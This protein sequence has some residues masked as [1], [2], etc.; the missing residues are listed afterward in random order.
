ELVV[1]LLVMKA[2]RFF[3]AVY[4]TVE[5]SFKV[6]NMNLRRYSLIH[7]VAL[8]QAL[9]FV[10][11]LGTEQYVFIVALLLLLHLFWCTDRVAELFVMLTASTAGIA[12]D[13][14]LTM[15][16]IYIFPAEPSFLPIP[17]WL[18][19][20]W[21]GFAGTLRHSMA[22]LLAKPK[23]FTAL[24]IVGA[25]LSYLAAEKLGAVEFSL[26]KLQTS[27]LVGLYWAALSPLFVVL[28]RRC[29]LNK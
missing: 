26:G 6:V 27:L 18:I 7:N 12:C 25:P 1:L 24:V 4:V 13:S 28:T 17:L 19:G 5:T 11:V 15:A 9:W 10:A 3:N 20:L 8:F 2:Q 21:L 22:P 16:G 29:C 14:M 23:L